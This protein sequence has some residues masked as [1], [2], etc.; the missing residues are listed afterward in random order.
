MCKKDSLDLLSG[1]W[2]AP[3]AKKP[4]PCL[5]YVVVHEMIHFLER[6]HGQ[7]FVKLIDFYMPDWQLRRNELNRHPLSHEDWRY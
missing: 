6:H 2:N 5:E 1:F 7:R 4:E 3:L